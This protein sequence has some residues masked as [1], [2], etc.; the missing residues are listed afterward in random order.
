MLCRAG[1]ATLLENEH[2][3]SQAPSAQ[4]E[5]HVRTPNSGLEERRLQCLRRVHSRLANRSF[6]SPK[7]PLTLRNWPFPRR[8]PHW[9]RYA[10]SPAYVHFL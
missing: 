2:I 10:Q 9:E 4:A 3:A 5:R 8:K 1:V 7:A 6:L